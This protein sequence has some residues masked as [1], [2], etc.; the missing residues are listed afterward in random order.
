MSTAR[1]RCGAA[2][3]LPWHGCR[4]AAVLK[5]CA[6]CGP[7]V[8]AWVQQE[9]HS[10]AG[11]SSP[12][13]LPSSTPASACPTVPRCSGRAP[14]ACAAMALERV[15][16]LSARPAAQAA[17]FEREAGM[18][19]SPR[20]W[21]GSWPPRSPRGTMAPLTWRARSPAR[22]CCP[23][24]TAAAPRWW[25]LARPEARGAASA[26]ACPHARQRASARISAR[27]H[28]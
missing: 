10:R 7:R 27:Q 24:R 11:G 17:G 3:D 13:F 21:S 8:R 1:G 18:T 15:P 26:H 20:R 14:A 23:L 22:S 5:R 2:T 16:P 28:A 6:G 4:I 12:P 25:R 19:S 9:M